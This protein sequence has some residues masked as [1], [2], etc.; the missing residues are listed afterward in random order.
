MQDNNLD[1]DVYFKSVTFYSSK[2][3]LFQAIDIQ[4]NEAYTLMDP[5]SSNHSSIS[6][7]LWG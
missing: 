3:S 7:Y 5:P 6:I 2:I 1:F 4:V